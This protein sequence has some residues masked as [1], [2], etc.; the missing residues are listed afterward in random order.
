MRTDEET[1]VLLDF[2]H[3][4]DKSQRDYLIYEVFRKYGDNQSIDISI[5]EMKEILGIDSTPGI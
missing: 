2:L 5:E 4:L 1:K 3:T